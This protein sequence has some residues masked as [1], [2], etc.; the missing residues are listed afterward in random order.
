VVTALARLPGRAEGLGGR[1]GG[2]LRR[3][4]RGRGMLQVT[5]LLLQRVDLRALG[6]SVG[7][8]LG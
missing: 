7:G 8:D 1:C 5:D 4:V 2:R 3:G 6:R